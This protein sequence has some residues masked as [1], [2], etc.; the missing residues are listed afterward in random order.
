[1]A[2]RTGP[3]GRGRG[4]STPKNDGG[5]G[6]S[7]NSSA[8]RPTRSFSLSR[9]LITLLDGLAE[10]EKSGFVEEALL[11]HFHNLKQRDDAIAKLT[12]IAT[13]VF[14]SRNSVAAHHEWIAERLSGLESD[15][16][17]VVG[18]LERLFHVRRHPI[19]LQT[20]S[21]DDFHEMIAEA[22]GEYLRNRSLLR[23]DMMHQKTELEVA[24]SRE[25]FA[26]RLKEA[27]E[28]MQSMPFMADGR[29]YIK[30]RHTGPSLYDGDFGT[31]GDSFD[32]HFCV[33]NINISMDDMRMI[34]PSERPYFE[35]HVS[36]QRPTLVAIGSDEV[37]KVLP[38]IV[39]DY[40][41]FRQ[42]NGAVPKG[43]SFQAEDSK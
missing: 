38:V 37:A 39:A 6:S 19:E 10:G 1:M 42:L 28:L 11:N 32:K 36:D 21:T 31:V 40:L 33:A 15:V 24:T 30:F 9:D 22:S 27:Q 14:E 7:A 43:P 2:G 3:S 4:P 25:N 18:V 26:N 16:G 20:P 41:A 8:K 5:D 17:Y 34:Y 13:F 29:F 35:L 23:P 12:E